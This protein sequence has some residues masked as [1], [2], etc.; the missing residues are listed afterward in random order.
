[1]TVPLTDSPVVIVVVDI[2]R[3][4]APS[5]GR[6]GAVLTIVYAAA[7]ANSAL[8]LYY[9]ILVWSRPQTSAKSGGDVDARKHLS[10]IQG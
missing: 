6:V 10:M 4:G 3:E 1:M 2:T 5:Q 8:L 9:C 7:V